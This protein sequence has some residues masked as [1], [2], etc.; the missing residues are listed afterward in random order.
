MSNTDLSELLDIAKRINSGEYNI[1]NIVIDRDNEL[2]SILKY[3]FDALESLK[4]I[5]SIVN[6]EVSK[7]SIFDSVLNDIR[8]LNKDTVE[9]IF[10]HVE[11]LNMNVDSIKE[12]IDLLR[13]NIN[14]NNEKSVTTTFEKLKDTILDGQ[15][16]CFDLITFLEFQDII[17]NK[18]YKLN[19]ILQEVTK[20]LSELLIKIGIYEGKVNLG[21]IQERDESKSSQDIVDELLKEFGL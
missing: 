3:F 6:N 1:E 10:S 17:R 15:G 16:L 2:Y 12:H 18:I 14:E 9:K 8:H 4:E 19:N 5:S 11:K 7:F 20:R 13:N 21:D